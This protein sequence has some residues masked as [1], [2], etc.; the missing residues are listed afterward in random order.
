M[1]L[2]PP[3]ML[4]VNIEKKPFKSLKELFFYTESKLR[5]STRNQHINE[6]VHIK[7]TWEQIGGVQMT[8]AVSKN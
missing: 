6:S 3:S 2:L 1:I 7:H 5:F 4:K 8:G